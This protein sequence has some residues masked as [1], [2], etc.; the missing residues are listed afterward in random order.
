MKLTILDEEWVLLVQNVS[1]SAAL[2]IK[3][4][5]TRRSDTLGSRPQQQNCKRANNS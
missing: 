3:L 4:V 2:P 5:E 1:L